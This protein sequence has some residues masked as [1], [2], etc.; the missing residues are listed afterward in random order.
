MSL[1]SI[2]VLFTGTVFLTALLY[3]MLSYIV[4]RKKAGA[5]FSGDSINNTQTKPGSLG[6]TSTPPEKPA[7]QL[8]KIDSP[9]QR[10]KIHSVEMPRSALRNT[11]EYPKSKRLEII[12]ASAYH[13]NSFSREYYRT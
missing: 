10:V 6:V 5:G 3:L 1:A 4:S 2:S 11:S 9:S 7:P 12:N 13:V 8:Y